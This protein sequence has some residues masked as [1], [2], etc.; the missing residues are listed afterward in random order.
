MLLPAS[1]RG[2]SS[3]TLLNDSKPQAGSQAYPDDARMSTQ[4]HAP[5]LLVFESG[6][7]SQQHA[8]MLANALAPALGLQPRLIRGT[9]MFPSATSNPA[10]VSW[11]HCGSMRAVLANATRIHLGHSA[12]ATA[13]LVERVWRQVSRAN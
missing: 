10:A 4:P 2:I 13:G 5:V 9:D 8:E 6:Q 7:Q 11:E 1:G 3:S 12:A